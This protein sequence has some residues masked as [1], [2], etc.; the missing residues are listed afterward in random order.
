MQLTDDP[1]DFA[2]RRLDLP[3]TGPVTM[4]AALLVDPGAFD[5]ASQSAEDNLYM[6]LS[7]RVDRARA[8]RQHEAVGEALRA[9]GVPT[10]TLPS[11]SGLPD[12]VFP[13]NVYA[14]APGVAVIGSMCHPVRRAEAARADARHLLGA[15]LGRRLI[16]LSDGPVGELTGVLAIDQPRRAAICG[17][18]GRCEPHAVAPMAEALGLELVL[19]TPLVPEEYHLNVVCAVLA[20]RA[21]VVFDGAFVD[22][23]V[24]EG[25]ER[26]W[27][28]AVHHLTRE[29]KDA[30][31]ANC[32]AFAPDA[33]GLSATAEDALT[34]GTRAF[35]ERMG[36]TRVPVDVCELEKGGGSLRCLVAEVF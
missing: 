3:E 15:T 18:T 27:P 16:D 2:R 1:F 21:V 23:R 35:F 5:V 19:V 33:V 13:N 28:G 20:G 6:D 17:L 30:F 24:P 8:R 10:I 4:G 14:T 7:A 22:P 12:A 36:F 29:E 25:L 26:A 31:A 11:V 34:E 9:C 32:L